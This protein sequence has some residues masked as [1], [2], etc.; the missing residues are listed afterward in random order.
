MVYPNKAG[1]ILLKMQ[2]TIQLYLPINQSSGG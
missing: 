1:G 2:G